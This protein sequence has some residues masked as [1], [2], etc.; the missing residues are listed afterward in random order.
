M[1]KFKIMQ[2]TPYDSPGTKNPKIKFFC[3]IPMGSPPTVAPNRG[4]VG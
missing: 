2:T 3:E 1:A 4:G